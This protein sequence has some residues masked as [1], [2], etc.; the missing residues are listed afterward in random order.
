MGTVIHGSTSAMRKP[1]GAMV[2]GGLDQWLDAVGV[3]NVPGVVYAGLTQDGLVKVGYSAS[4][5][6]VRARFKSLARDLGGPIKPLLV[7]PGGWPMEALLHQEFEAHWVRGEF[8]ST[9]APVLARL[10]EL[11]SSAHAYTFVAEVKSTVQ[12]TPNYSW[13]E[14]DF[15][16]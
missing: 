12:A 9:D 13:W 10:M 8:Y 5:K 6:N 14:L 3:Q 11:A 2:L 15:D 4:L 7:H 16:I 1:N